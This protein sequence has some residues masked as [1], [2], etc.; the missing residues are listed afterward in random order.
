MKRKPLGNAAVMVLDALARGSKYG[1]DIMDNTGLKSGTVYRALSRLEE[2][3]L[4][5][6]KWETARIAV[7]EGLEIV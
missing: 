3:G 4:V 1:F 6:S 2:L 7:Q 5:S